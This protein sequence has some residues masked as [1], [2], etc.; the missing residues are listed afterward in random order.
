[1]VNNVVR[2]NRIWEQRNLNER[3]FYAVQYKWH[4]VT[5]KGREEKE[6]EKEVE[7][8]WAVTQIESGTKHY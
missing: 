2:C 5:L 4:G 7:R 6:R 3:V 8:E 1:M